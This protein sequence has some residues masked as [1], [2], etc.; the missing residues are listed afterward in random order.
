MGRPVKFRL[1][2]TRTGVA[3]PTKLERKIVADLDTAGL[4]VFKQHLDELQAYKAIFDLRCALDE[5]DSK[6]VQSAG[7]AILDAQALTDELVDALSGEAAN[8]G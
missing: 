4:P 3:I 8:V 5:L 1:L 2:I 6:A 7:R